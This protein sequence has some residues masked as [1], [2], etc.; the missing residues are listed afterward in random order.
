MI[1]RTKA[2]TQR[3][4]GKELKRSMN[5][6]YSYGI[7]QWSCCPEYRH[8]KYFSYAILRQHIISIC[9]NISYEHLPNVCT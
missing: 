9:T 7:L 5:E 1:N 3:G 2:Y 8:T 4:P 6:I